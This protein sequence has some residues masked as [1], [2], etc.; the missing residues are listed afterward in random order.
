VYQ[1]NRRQHRNRGGEEGRD[2]QRRQ[3]KAEI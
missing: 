1:R 3:R 2:Q